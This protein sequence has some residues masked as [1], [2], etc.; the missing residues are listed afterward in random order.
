[1]H[2]V[3]LLKGAIDAHNVVAALI[4]CMVQASQQTLLE[5]ASAL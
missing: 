2:L 4:T 3:P 5:K 1:M